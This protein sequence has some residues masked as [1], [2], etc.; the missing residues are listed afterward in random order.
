MA[1]NWSNMVSCSSLHMYFAVGRRKNCFIVFFLFVKI[2]KGG[3]SAPQAVVGELQY[4]YNVKQTA[5][6][7]IEKITINGAEQLAKQILELVDQ[8]KENLGKYSNFRI[9][10]KS[11][12][13]WIYFTWFFFTAEHHESIEPMATS[14]NS[15]PAPNAHTNE[16]DDD[17]NGMN[18]LSSPFHEL[19]EFRFL[20]WY[21][22]EWTGIPISV[23][24]GGNENSTHDRLDANHTIEN[25]DAT[26]PL[27]SP[28]SSGISQS[29]VDD[30]IESNLR[31]TDGMETLFFCCCCCF[32][33]WKMLERF[34]FCI[35]FN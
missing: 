25:V 31:A 24:S 4:Q 30:S 7:I 22:F 21:E 12:W 13:N 3:P 34:S 33:T 20:F 23:D 16:A 18:F 5:K 29:V 2:Q 10:V 35:S 27:P 17:A 1:P 28:I 14:S 26:I 32:H 9:L 6:Q 11:S 8:E 19:W 15:T